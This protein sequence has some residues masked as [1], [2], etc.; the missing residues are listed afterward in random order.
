MEIATSNHLAN[1][2]LLVAQNRTRFFEGKKLLFHA[3][4]RISVTN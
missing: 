1:L 2:R 4:L 3:L